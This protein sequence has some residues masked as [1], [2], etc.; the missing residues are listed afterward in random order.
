VEVVILTIES[1]KNKLIK[2]QI[3]CHELTAKIIETIEENH[4]LGAFNTICKEKAINDAKIVDEKIKNNYFLPLMGVP[5]SAKD[6]ICTK[7]IKTT[8]SSKMLE[9]YVPPYSSVAYDK[10]IA[11]N[12]ICIGKNSMDE[13]AMGSSSQNSAPNF[14]KPKNPYDMS[15]IPG[16]SSGGSAVSVSANLCTFS[17]GT[18]TGGSVVQ[19]SAL[20]G[21]TGIKPT[22]GT[23]SR[24]GIVAYGSSL[25]QIGII[26]NNALDCATVLNIISGI[27]ENDHTSVK[28]GISDYKNKIN[29]S[30]NDFKIGIPKEF[31]GEGINEKIKTKVME[32]AHFYE[33]LGAKIIECSL[34]SFRHAI[35]AYYLI[36]CSEASSNLARFDGI[37]YGF[38]IEKA[39]NYDELIKKNRTEGF[40]KEVKKRILLG[41]YALSSGYY[42][43]YYKKAMKIRM[44]I[45]QEYEE[46]FKNVNVLLTPTTP[47]TA[48][49]IKENECCV[50]ETYASDICTVTANIA[51]IPVISTTCGYDNE[52]MPIGMSISGKHFQD[53]LII[54]ITDLFEKNFKKNKPKFFCEIDI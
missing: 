29:I 28:S 6:N 27:D 21:V 41:N 54:A 13:F 42:D 35:S 19:P 18:D 44:K 15:K 39:S 16:G 25:D 48:K 3:S 4:E 14:P 34:P 37:R 8:C 46:I 24:F 50:N 36:A 51:G 49:K 1:V 11:Q 7:G 38:K 9:N 33:K 23:I 31:F 10:L 47:N 52:N 20:C 22:Y 12:S 32:A 53:D 2:K 26:A 5:F 30:A 40:G 17:L 43:E 45:K